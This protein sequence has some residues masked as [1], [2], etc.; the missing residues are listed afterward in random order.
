MICYKDMTF[1]S[2]KCGTTDCSRNWTED[3]AQA[4]KVWWGSERAP[5]AF[6]DYSYTCSLYKP[7]P[8]P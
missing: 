3:K 8:R 1:C 5:V 2:A 4:A 6:R 7:E